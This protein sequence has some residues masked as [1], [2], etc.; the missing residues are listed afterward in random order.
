MAADS[1]N[2][3]NILTHQYTTSNTNDRILKYLNFRD[4]FNNDL[5]GIFKFS[6]ALNDSSTNKP[7]IIN[8]AESSTSKCDSNVPSKNIELRIDDSVVVENYT[9]L[10]WDLYDQCYD[11]IFIYEVD[12][13]SGY[14]NLVEIS[15][16]KETRSIF[17]S[18]SEL[19]PLTFLIGG[20]RF[21]DKVYKS[22]PITIN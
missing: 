19:L 1:I 12:Q 17:I 15:F 16:P 4:D 9:T 7:R 20:N 5:D 8:T 3:K 22:N 21:G 6:I 13:I 2:F 11:Q 14:E 10:T 18:D